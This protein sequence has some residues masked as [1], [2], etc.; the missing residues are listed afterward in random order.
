MTIKHDII[1]INKDLEKIANMLLLNGSLLESPG[2]WYGRMGVA[3]FFFHY[4]QY[5]G[6]ELFEDYAIEI[7][8]QIQKEIHKDSPTD[9]DKGIAGIGV[10]IQYL[11]DNH[12]LDIDTDVILEDFDYRIR[13]DIMY[14]PQEN[15]SLANGLTGLGQYLLYRTMY[16]QNIDDKTRLLKNQDK[17]IH[18][19]NLLE[20]SIDSSNL[21]LPDILSFLSRLYS[22]NLCNPKIE[23]CISKFLN[24]YSQD[25]ISTENHPDWVLALIRIASV[26]PSMAKVA[27]QSIE[28]ILQNI[29][30]TGRI[31]KKGIDPDDP[32]TLL[33]LLRYKRIIRQTNICTS[34]I[35]RL[36]ILI[37]TC[38]E[39]LSEIRFEYKK[40]SLTGC[41]GIGLAFMTIHDQIEDTWVDLFG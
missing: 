15:N 4:S 36:D 10:G 18:I 41:A 6:N 12:F 40:L 2:L 8:G 16:P 22:L 23:C 5:T 21:Y 38:T 28:Q 31:Q 27:E 14:S 19:V 3:I 25:I 26:Y 37:S 13:H 39:Q 29:S 17:T 1:K 24:F 30:Q 33:C 9:Y 34:F 35:P 20:H 11:A 7:I 32:Y